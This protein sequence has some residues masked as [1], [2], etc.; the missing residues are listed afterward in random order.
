MPESVLHGVKKG[1]L[2]G[3]ATTHMP[4]LDPLVTMA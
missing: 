1:Y 3:W 2:L 4:E